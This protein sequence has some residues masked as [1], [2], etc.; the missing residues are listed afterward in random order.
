MIAVP[1]TTRGGK[2]RRHVPPALTLAQ[3]E[4]AR[5]ARLAGASLKE[6][7]RTYRVSRSTLQ[8]ALFREGAY[9]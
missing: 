6:L 9:A 7:M 1:K 2:R 8:R 3:A 4:Q 5:A